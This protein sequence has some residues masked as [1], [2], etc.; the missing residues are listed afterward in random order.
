MCSILKSS[1]LPFASI[2]I[3]SVVQSQNCSEFYRTASGKA[4]RMDYRIGFDF[5]CSYVITNYYTVRIG[6]LTRVGPA[7][8]FLHIKRYTY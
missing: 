5:A 1:K 3:S 4:L 8:N 2:I 7:I 6:I